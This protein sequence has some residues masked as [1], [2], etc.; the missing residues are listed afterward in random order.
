MPNF[1]HAKFLKTHM[2]MQLLNTHIPNAGGKKIHVHCSCK[3][4]NGI[5]QTSDRFKADICL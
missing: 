5:L 3:L 2:Y 1:K 4:K